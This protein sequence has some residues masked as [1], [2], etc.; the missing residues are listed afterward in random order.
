[1]GGTLIA[2]GVADVRTHEKMLEDPDNYRPP[3]CPA[4]HHDR[5]HVHDHPSRVLWNEAER[6]VEILRFQCGSEECGAT[7]RIVPGFLARRL[8]HRWAVV[9]QAAMDP[10][11]GEERCATSLIRAPSERTVRR[12]R[13]RLESCA[14]RLV[15][16]LATS[17]S[18]ALEAIASALGL[19]ATRYDL[20]RTH[21]KEVGSRPG[22]RLCE[23]AALVHRLEPG[24]RLM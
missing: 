6:V 2:E 10:S 20:V 21:A 12:W 19:E 23:V 5:L 4:C 9:E 13:E 3:E 18:Q 17:G 7:W 11:P 15:Q 1:L 8:W 24:I 14:R 22:C 16:L